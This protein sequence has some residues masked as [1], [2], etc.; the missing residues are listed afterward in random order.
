LRS[1]FILSLFFFLLCSCG[2]KPS[3]EELEAIDLA[4]DYL[5]YN[6]CK[7]AIDILEDVGRNRNNPI[8]LGVLASAYSCRAEYSD[9]TFL[10]TELPKIDTSAA[11]L[12]KSLTQLTWSAEIIADS[13]QYKDLRESLDIVLNVDANEPSQAAREA[14]Y[15]PRKAGDL[16]VQ[17][18]LLSLT[19]LGKFLHF[20][21]NVNAIGSKGLGAASVNEQTASPSN[22][23]MNYT[24]ARALAFLGGGGGGVC[25]GDEGHPNMSFGA[26]DLVTTKRRLCEGLM[27]VT[28]I[29]DILNNLTL[30]DS[31]GDLSAT[32]ATVNTFKTTVTTADPALAT[33]INT[34]S[35]STCETLVA[36]GEF[37]NLQYIYALLFEAGLP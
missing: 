20:Y 3:E 23:F 9:T 26:P 18:L 34:T 12:L 1:A 13:S 11:N 22:C 25:D 14:K 36:A 27:I 24:D 19:Q 28:N 5:S 31:I 6:E 21:G 30:P 10:I 15:G 35:Q 8:Y 17:A 16:G 33:L 2:K 4:L 37:N 7:K 32:A 29:I